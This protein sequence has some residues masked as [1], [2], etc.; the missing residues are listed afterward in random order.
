M[1]Y[2]TRGG[3]SY[4]TKAKSFQTN[5]IPQAKKLQY[6]TELE[7]NIYTN[8]HLSKLHCDPRISPRMHLHH[9]QMSYPILAMCQK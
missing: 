4:S 2:K 6:P 7:G 5:P 3:F 1:I 9:W 8:F